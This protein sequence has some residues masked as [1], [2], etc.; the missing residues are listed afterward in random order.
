MRFVQLQLKGAIYHVYPMS[1][2][3]TRIATRMNG[4]KVVSYERDLTADGPLKRRLQDMAG[5]IR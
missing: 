1:G 3:V 2:R 5:L 4:H